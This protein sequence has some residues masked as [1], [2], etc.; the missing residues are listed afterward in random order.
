MICSNNLFIGEQVN[1]ELAE[2]YFDAVDET[3]RQL[4]KHPKMGTRNESG[5]APLKSIR[6]FP[7]SGFEMYLVF[8]LPHEH[9]ID[10]VRVLQVLVTSAVSSLKRKLNSLISPS[11]D[12]ASRN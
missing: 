8:Y 11:G 9:G 7:V 1:L 4:V 6:R 3:C 12:W 2:R 10:V 5:N